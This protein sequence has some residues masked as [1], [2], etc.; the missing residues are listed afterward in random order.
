M[1]MI[2]SSIYLH[3]RVRLKSKA[4]KELE[5]KKNTVHWRVKQAIIKGEKKI[6]RFAMCFCCL[7]K[8]LCSKFTNAPTEKKMKPFRYLIYFDTGA[9]LL[10]QQTSSDERLKKCVILARQQEIKTLCEW[11]KENIFPM[12]L[13]A[14]LICYSTHCQCI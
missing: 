1:F 14:T 13:S 6:H 4:T 5:K 9:A 2:F 3:R 12:F 11:T 8:C 10:L 7:Q